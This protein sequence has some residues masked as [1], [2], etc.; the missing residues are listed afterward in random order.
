MADIIAGRWAIVILS[1]KMILSKK[2]INN[3]IRKPEMSHCILSVVVD[4]AHVISH[5][6]SGFRKKYGTLGV[7]RTLLPKGTPVVAMSA[8]LA[9]DL[10]FLIPKGRRRADE[11][12]KGFIYA[13]NVS[14]GLDMVDYL[15]GLL[16]TELQGMG[17]IQPYNAGLSKE[18][19]D[20]VMGL[21]KVGIMRILVCTDAAGMGCNIPDID[22]VVQLKLTATVSAFVQRAGRAAHMPGQTGLAVLLVEKS[23]YNADLDKGGQD[24]QKTKGKKTIR[25]SSNY[26]KAKTKE[27]VIKCGVRRGAY[28]GLFDEVATGVDVPVDVSSIDEAPTVPC[29]DVCN[30]ELLNHTHPAPPQPNS[31][32]TAASYEAINPTTKSS[33][34]EW[35]TKIWNRDFDDAIF[36]PAGIL[37]DGA[38]K[39][40]ASMASPIE[41]LIGLESVIGGWAWFGTYG[42]ELLAEI[43]TL[44]FKSIPNQKQKRVAKWS[45]VDEADGESLAK[46]MC[47]SAAPTPQ[48][49]MCV[50]VAPTPVQP[51]MSPPIAGPSTPMHAYPYSQYPQSVMLGHPWTIYY[52]PSYYLTPPRNY[53]SPQQPHVY[54]PYYPS[55]NLYHQLPP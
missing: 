38:L 41:N 34:T 15:D 26:P 12:P 33:L 46:R 7:L 45:M 20:L 39:K 36:S 4:E 2:F 11:V 6:G 25:Q 48:V 22:I 27:Y 13:D 29:C 8:T 44:P 18:C 31:W 5:W 19:H 37:S 21:F 35:H 47:V 32:K 10:E 40:L 54:Y 53:N 23:I 52:R 1:P 50:A 24:K 3:V 42:D 9:G 28:G 17:L 55:A 43:K 30:P 49:V 14:G 51:T 16:P